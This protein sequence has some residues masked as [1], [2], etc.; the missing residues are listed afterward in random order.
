MTLKQSCLSKENKLMRR[1]IVAIT[2]SVLGLS[3]TGCIDIDAN[4]S[5]LIRIITIPFGGKVQF[6]S[7]KSINAISVSDVIN[8]SPGT[9][10]SLVDAEPA[11]TYDSTTPAQALIKV[12]TDNGQ[13]FS[14]SFPMLPTDGSS[15][16]P[17]SSETVTNAFA[18]QNPSDVS[19]FIQS[20]ASHANATV[21]VDVQ[22]QTTFQG[23]QDGSSH[24]VIGRQYS[25]SAGVT[26]LGSATYTAPS[27]SNCG[28]PGTDG[29]TEKQ[30]CSN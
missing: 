4:V 11:L 16:V 19:A 18:V 12:T 24:T 1:W 13:T 30:F 27:P 8:S 28:N 10:N 5:V 21:S 25:P 26:N 17:A 20:A 9:V 29:F 22:T 23:P 2:L 14:Q 15:F 7:E 6:F 3:C